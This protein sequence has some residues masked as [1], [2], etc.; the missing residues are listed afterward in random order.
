MS[1]RDSNGPIVL[2][3]GG[4][5]GHIYPLIAVGEELTALGV[6]FVFIGSKDSQEEKAV[7]NLKW[8][9]LSISSGKWRRY[10][11]LSS[12]FQNIWDLLKV[13]SGFFQAIVVI[14]KLR[15]RVV[16]CKGGYV[17]LPVAIAARVCGVRLIVHE[18]DVIMGLSNRIASRF[19]D[20]VF[21]MFQPSAYPKSDS[22]YC[23]AGIPIR[24]SL[25]QAAS[26]KAPRKSR[27][28]ILVLPGSQGSQKINSLLGEVLPQI[29]VKADLVH[30]TGERDYEK[31]LSLK[32]K[33]PEKLKG[34][35][36]VFSF[37]DRELPYY[38][39]T[40]DILICRA[41]AT[42][43]AEAAL[44]GKALYLI[45]LPNAAADHQTKNAQVLQKIGAA[46]VR[47]ESELIGEKVLLDLRDL[48]ENPTNLAKLGYNLRDYLNEEASLDIIVKEL[49][50]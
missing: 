8:R 37:I 1:R 38:Y 21:T 13:I 22:R 28:L 39:Q 46:I 35:Y 34:C 5:G 27:P 2:A 12:F 42:T 25:R 6:P 49:T 18:S 3:G 32:D 17:A 33:L 31:Y 30:M 16:F 10:F 36:K 7:E 15:P 11:T 9:F 50:K 41:S 43:I 45:P 48:L 24:K 29:L 47:R 40:A 14:K 4:T 44:F 20:R 23:Q 26:L 19:A